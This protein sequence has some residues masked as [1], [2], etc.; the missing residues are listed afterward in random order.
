MARRHDVAATRSVRCCSPRA[1]VMRERKWRS[2]AVDESCQAA[3]MRPPPPRPSLARISNSRPVHT[4]KA[5]PI[6]IC[7]RAVISILGFG[8]R[9]LTCPGGQRR[10]LLTHSLARSFTCVCMCVCPVLFASLALLRTPDNEH[11]EHQTFTTSACARR[12]T[13]SFRTRH[14]G[15]RRIDR[16]GVAEWKTSPQLAHFRGSYMYELTSRQVRDPNDVL[17]M[18]YTST[19][20]ETV[21]MSGV[22]PTHS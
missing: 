16:T 6:R 4:P 20:T 21:E 17:N 22:L 13:R 2:S 3:V 10:R 7:R 15:R 9:Q 12:V 1:V 11:A 5:D 19:T 14:E 8:C 18:S